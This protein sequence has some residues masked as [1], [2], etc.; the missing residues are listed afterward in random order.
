MPVGVFW[1]KVFFFTKVLLVGD[2]V[3]WT[4]QHIT[5][6][7]F[8]SRGL[9]KFEELRMYFLGVLGLEA[10]IVF[11]YIHCLYNWRKECLC[12]DI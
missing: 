11:L 5:F 2:F 4:H 6:V 9:E 8:I 7:C 1:E 10:F 3:E 12:L